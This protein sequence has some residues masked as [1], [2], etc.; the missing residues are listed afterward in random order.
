MVSHIYTYVPEPSTLIKYND[1]GVIT[2]IIG[3]HG[4]VQLDNNI[5]KMVSLGSNILIVSKSKL[6]E[7]SL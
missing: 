2:A 6:K 7:L 1:K 5:T 4:I 3:T